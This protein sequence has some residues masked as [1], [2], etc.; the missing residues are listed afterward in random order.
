[1]RSGPNMW[2]SL[3]TKKKENRK[4]QALLQPITRRCTTVVVNFALNSTT[5]TQK[6]WNTI[7]NTSPGQY[8]NEENMRQ[9]SYQT[10]Q[11]RQH[12]IEAHQVSTFA[13]TYICKGKRERVLWKAGILCM[14]GRRAHMK[15]PQVPCSWDIKY[16]VSAV[17]IIIHTYSWRCKW[18]K[19]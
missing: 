1:M 17:L 16:F 19:T 13:A 18:G 15:Y 14:L 10:V 6:T 8:R 7:L 2:S 4:K 11:V 9:V 3:A 5:Q 12:H